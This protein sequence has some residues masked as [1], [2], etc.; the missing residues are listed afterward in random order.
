MGTDEEILARRQSKTE[1]ID[2]Y[3]QTVIPGISDSHTHM[4]LGA[5]KLHGFNLSTP[6]FSITPDNPDALVEK[7]NL[8]GEPSQRQTTHRAK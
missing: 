6:E 5:M 2:L 1:V 4:W 8:R 3:R 7:I